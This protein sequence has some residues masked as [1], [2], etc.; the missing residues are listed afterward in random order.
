MHDRPPYR[1]CLSQL[2]AHSAI[3]VEAS[4][5][6]EVYL[7]RAGD[8]DFGFQDRVHFLLIA[9]RVTRQVLVDH[10]R[11]RAAKKRSS[12]GFDVELMPGVGNESKAGVGPVELLDLDAAL[13]TLECEEQALA[14]LIEMRYFGGMT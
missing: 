2:P 1:E 4:G 14:Q 9:S 11:A 10:A 7:K 12:E 8:R 13:A 5:K 3:A 6:H